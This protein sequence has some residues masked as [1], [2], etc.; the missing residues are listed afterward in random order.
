M[1]KSVGVGAVKE[2]AGLSGESEDPH[3]FSTYAD[4]PLQGFSTRTIAG[5]AQVAYREKLK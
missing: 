1:Y 3:R 5:R 4:P 2:T